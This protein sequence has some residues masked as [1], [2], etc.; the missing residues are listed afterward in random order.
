MFLLEGYTV[1]AIPP[2]VKL[3]L[4]KMELD[5][6]FKKNLGVYSMSHLNVK[7]GSDWLYKNGSFKNMFGFEEFERNNN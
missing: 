3:Q 5:G 2:K 1:Y 7:Y 4:D 6:F